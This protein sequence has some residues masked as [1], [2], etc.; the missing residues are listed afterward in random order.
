MTRRS[1]ILI[2]MLLAVGALAW[3]AY[4]LGTGL[5]RD[6]RLA[7]QD[8]LA[9]LKTEFNLS[10]AELREVRSLHEGY[11]PQC[12]SFCQKIADEKAVL[13]AALDRGAPGNEL[14]NH[15]AQIALLR[16]QCQAAMLQHFEQ[17]SRAMNQEQGRRYLAEMRQLTLGSHE[18]I[19]HSMSSSSPSPSAGHEGHRH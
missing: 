13:Q 16:A 18:A 5:A 3:G 11:L 12:H 4:H 19:E 2:L 6:Q 7:T 1:W 10:E 8:D 15:L 14:S 9:W 17:V